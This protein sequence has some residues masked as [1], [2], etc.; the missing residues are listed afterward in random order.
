MLKIKWNAKKKHFDCKILLV[1]LCGIVI[2]MFITSV[3]FMVLRSCLG[4][5]LCCNKHNF[6]FEHWTC[7]E[8]LI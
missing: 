7:D 5:G 8:S 1:S 2:A 4:F 3:A 6:P